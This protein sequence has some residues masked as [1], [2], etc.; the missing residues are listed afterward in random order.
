MKKIAGLEG[1][2]VSLQVAIAIAMIVITILVAVVG[3]AVVIWG[4]PGALSFDDYLNDVL[5]FAG[6]VG[7]V[8]I[9]GGLS[10]AAA[11]KSS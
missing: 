11:K 1:I 9:G 6:A 8:T 7:L 4:N 3:G 2:H 10:A 5:K